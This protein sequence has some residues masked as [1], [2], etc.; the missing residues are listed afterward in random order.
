MYKKIKIKSIAMAPRCH[1]NT[2]AISN[3]C[4]VPTAEIAANDKW[5]LRVKDERQNYKVK[6][7]GYF[8]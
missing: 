5:E 2:A 8:C 4:A 6:R 1:G 3:P 7:G